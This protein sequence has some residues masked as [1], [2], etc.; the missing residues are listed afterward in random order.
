VKAINDNG[1]K[2]VITTVQGGKLTASLKDGK[3]I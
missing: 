3:V 1:G 2:F